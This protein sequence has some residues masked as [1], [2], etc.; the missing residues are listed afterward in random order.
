M[1]LTVEVVLAHRTRAL[2]LDARE[3]IRMAPQTAE[4]MAAELG[5]GQEWTGKQVESFTELAN[6][7]LIGSD[8]RM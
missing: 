2:F 3:S 4:L 6:G 1:A 8:R 7:Y 5:Y